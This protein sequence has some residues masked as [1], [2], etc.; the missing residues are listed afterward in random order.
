MAQIQ[1]RFEGM[2]AAGVKP[3]TEHELELP[4]RELPEKLLAENPDP[5]LL[6]I[7]CGNGWV[8]LFL[9]SRG[10]RVTGIDSS[11]TAI[12]EARKR[13]QQIEL[14][15]KTMFDVGD[16]LA[17]PYG[18]ASFDAVLDR[19]FFHHVPEDEYP[20]Y[21]EQVT[22]VLKDGL[23][24]RGQSPLQRGE[25]GLLSLHAFTKRNQRMAHEFSVEDIERIFGAHFELLEH[26]EDA[27]PNNAPAHLGHYLLRKKAAG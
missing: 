9:A 19:G 12:E 7:G 4:I 16:G 5:G 24:S 25:G 11:P 13:A 21:F 6:D 8:S 26:S 10:I 15:D 2:F 3:W 18:D 27:W 23:P 14:E 20:K 17:L 22:R 1:E